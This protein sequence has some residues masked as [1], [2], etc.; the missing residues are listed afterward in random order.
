MNIQQAYNIWA[1]SYDTV[2]NKTRDL[3]AVALRAVLP[4]TSLAHIVELGCGTGKNTEW[5]AS[6]TNRLTAVDFSADMLAKAQAR[7][8]HPHVTFWQADIIQ[9]WQF[10]DAPADLVTCSLILEHIQDLNS[11]FA[12][13]S[14][15]LRP[16][17]LFYI[18]ELHP[19]KQYQGSKARFETA[20]GSVLELECYVH[21]VSDFME[22]AKRYGLVCQ[23][24]REWF[25]DDRNGTPRVLSFLLA[26]RD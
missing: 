15:A 13:A 18:G 20:A 11:V 6:K 12:Q 14:A 16:G 25:D 19:F 21:H 4:A 5:L 17:G 9:P 7:N 8:Q 24:L 3:E 2:A 23:D 10:L 22:A 26:K 1:E